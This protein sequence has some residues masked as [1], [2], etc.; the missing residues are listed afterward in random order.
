ML[1]RAT[2]RSLPLPAR[3][4]AAA[5]SVMATD[6]L[7]ALGWRPRGLVVLEAFVRDAAR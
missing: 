4:D 7:A 1:G 2:G 6:R 5:L 3:A